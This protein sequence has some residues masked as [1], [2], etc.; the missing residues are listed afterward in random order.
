MGERG[1]MD[2]WTDKVQKSK[3]SARSKADADEDRWQVWDMVMYDIG[4]RV[5]NNRGGQTD[6]N[7]SCRG[8][9]TLA[10]LM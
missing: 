10:I 7:C 6:Q 9:L 1:G 5:Q 2:V 4:A 3:E 8:E